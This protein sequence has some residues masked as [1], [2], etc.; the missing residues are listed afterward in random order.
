MSGA[1]RLASPLSHSHGPAPAASRQTRRIV[2]AVLVPAALAT[3]IAM[4]V[5]WPG[6]VRLDTTPDSGNRALG[7]VT[8]ID[9]RT[10]PDGTV[11]G[12]ATVRITDG[13]GAG[14]DAVVD[15]PQGPGAVR[16]AAGDDVVLLYQPDNRTY[17][18]VDH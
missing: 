6:R 1:G 18:V 15:L 13:P 9:A 11:C 5:L 3:I 2:T 12:T 16:L 17:A 7:T 4:T 14:T 8:A 10:C